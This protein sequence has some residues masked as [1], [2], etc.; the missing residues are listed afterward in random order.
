M[1]NAKEI[2]Y[3]KMEDAFAIKDF[4]LF[5]VFAMFVHLTLLTTY[6]GLDASAPLDI[7]Q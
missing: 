4:S 7:P 6:Q 3:I 5:K 2:K 1:H